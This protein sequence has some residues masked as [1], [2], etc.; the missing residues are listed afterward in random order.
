MYILLSS[1]LIFCNEGPGCKVQEFCCTSPTKTQVIMPSSKNTS[2]NAFDVPVLPLGISFMDGTTVLNAGLSLNQ[3]SDEEKGPFA[4]LWDEVKENT[5]PQQD[6]T[7]NKLP[8]LAEVV[9][10]IVHTLYGHMNASK[11]ASIGDIL[12]DAGINNDILFQG[13]YM[14]CNA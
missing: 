2:N 1:S 14:C 9:K 5:Q 7:P 13:R 3:F 12:V 11:Q 6:P 4:M 8:P 10:N